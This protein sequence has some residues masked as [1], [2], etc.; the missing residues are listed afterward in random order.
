[1]TIVDCR[2]LGDYV[3]WC[4]L[5]CV[6]KACRGNEL[7]AGMEV[8]QGDTDDAVGEPAAPQRIP[9]EADFLYAYSTTPGTY[10][11]PAGACWVVVI[12]E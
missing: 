8:E 4:V 7:D 5:V 12:S 9:I 11:R 1:M 6:W 3:G 10:G 2:L